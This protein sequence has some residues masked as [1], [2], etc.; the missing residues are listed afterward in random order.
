[1]RNPWLMK[2]PYM[3]L[4]LSGANAVAGKARGHATN[5]AHQQATKATQQ[6]MQVVMEAWMAPL[7]LAPAKP[8]RRRRSP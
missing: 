5:V 7:A 6:M 2:N 3:S 1:M 4:W 8:R